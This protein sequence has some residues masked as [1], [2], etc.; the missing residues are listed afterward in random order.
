MTDVQ[1]LSHLPGIYW[2]IPHDSI[3]WG[4][5]LCPWFPPGCWGHCTLGSS[6][7]QGKSHS[8]QKLPASS[9]QARGPHF[10]FHWYNHL[11][12]LTISSVDLEDVIAHTE[13]LTKFTQQAL[14]DNKQSLSLLNTEICLMSNTVLQK[15]MGLD[16]ITASQGGSWAVIQTECCIH[17]WWVC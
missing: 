5:H 2:V 13:A 3:S 1:W 16:I 17:T 15:R 9:P 12:S 14:N 11:A 8:Q 4:R 10:V 6:W 7:A